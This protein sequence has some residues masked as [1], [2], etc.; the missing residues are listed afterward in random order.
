MGNTESYISTVVF[1][2][3]YCSSFPL[4]V[5]IA[6]LSWERDSITTIQRDS[7]SSLKLSPFTK[8]FLPSLPSER[9]LFLLRM[10]KSLL[11]KYL[12]T[13]M[14]RQRQKFA[15]SCPAFTGRKRAKF[16]LDEEILNKAKIREM[17]NKS[18]FIVALHRTN[19]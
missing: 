6:L 12:P 2:L 10:I 4:S 15:T 1:E 7:T 17:R 16:Y 5:N 18:H 11:V 9:V 13:R 19:V 14:S 8:P 3:C